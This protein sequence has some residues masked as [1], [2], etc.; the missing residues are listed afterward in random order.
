MKKNS[1]FLIALQD[2]DIM[3]SEIKDK[4]TAK[5]LKEMGFELSGLKELE[6]AR[7]ELAEQ[8]SPAIL[9]RYEKLAVHYKI[10]I[11]P[12]TGDKC[13]GC[14]VRLP[15]SFFSSTTVVELITC[16]NCGRMLYIP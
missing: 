11:L 10:A 6:N 3:I 5:E 12:I 4:S 13:L 15:T 16:E 8:I 7:L 14:F 2:L 1:R 9:N